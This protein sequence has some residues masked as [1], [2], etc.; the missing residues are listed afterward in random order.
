MRNLRQARPKPWLL[1]A[2]LAVSTGGCS[3]NRQRVVQLTP[4][5]TTAD[6]TQ[7]VS[8]SKVQMVRSEATEIDSAT[9]IRPTIYEDAAVFAAMD[10]TLLNEA[11]DTLNEADGTEG[12]VEATP[13]AGN[14][15]TRS[16][17][18]TDSTTPPPSTGQPVEYFVGIALAGHPRIQ[19]ARHRVAAATNV[20]PQAKSLPDPMF[21]NTFWPLHDQALQTAG[22]RIAHQMSLSQGVPWPEK[23]RAKAAIASREVQIAQAEVDRIEREITESVRIAYYELWYA[24]RAIQIVDE[25]KDLVQDLTNV[26]EARYRSGGAQQDVL[27]AQSESDRLEDQRI[28]L[29]QQK[30][31]A[32]ADLAALLQQPVSMVPEAVD[33]LG[34]SDAPG[35]LD[36]LIASAEACSPELQGLAWEIQRDRERHRLAC[37]QKYPDLQVGVNLSI[38]SD[39]DDVLS[40][41]ANGH[42][43]LSFTVGTTLPIWRDKINAGIREAAHRTN[44]TAN[45]MEAE[46]DSLYGRLRRLLAQADSL[47]EQ[48]QLYEE[49]IIPRTEKTLQLS[50]ADYR[51]K[52][53]DFYSL[54]ETYRELLMF[55]TQ[56]ARFDATL[57]TTIARIDRTVGCPE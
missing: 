5:P 29:T 35:Q 26:A 37:L 49:R 14:E 16:T 56:L 36:Q 47:I 6:S 31:M 10:L 44:S 41:V 42:D 17:G 30:Q 11:D 18:V 25:T 4:P 57:A 50:V 19:A 46:R 15:K 40:G 22:G 33:D 28:Q 9:A 32:Q 8:E 45:R 23:R 27:R 53:T 13:D 20:I 7:S 38:V 52:R 51:G 24:T 34:I 54:I 2:M 1:L 21:N 12:D 55:E 48:R 3:A 43:N 39:D